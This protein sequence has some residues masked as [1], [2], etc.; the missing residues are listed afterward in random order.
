[1]TPSIDCL[2]AVGSNL[3]D[4]LEHLRAGIAAIDALHGVHVTD[5][6]SLYGTHQ[7][8]DPSSKGRISMPLFELRQHEMLRAY[9]P[10]CTVSKR[11]G[12]GFDAY[13]GAHAP[14]TLTFLFMVTP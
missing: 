1:M 4:R 3:G 5:V 11:N 14:S 9:F 7:L 2:I 10:N 6:S 13:A 8:G 12:I